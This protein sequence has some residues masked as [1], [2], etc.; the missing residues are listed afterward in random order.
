MLV[1]SAT[2]LSAFSVSRGRLR[3]QASRHREL[4]PAMTQVGIQARQP[5]RLFSTGR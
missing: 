3:R 1:S 4:G 2:K 5:M